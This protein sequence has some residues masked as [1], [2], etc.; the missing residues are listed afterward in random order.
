[1]TQRI[2]M[3]E[4]RSIIRALNRSNLNK[5]EFQTI[6][7]RIEE[8]TH[9]FQMRA[10]KLN[11][12][13]VLYRSN[14]Y[15][16]KPENV[17]FFSYPP[18][19]KVNGYQRCNAPK[20]PMFYCTPDPKTTYAELRLNAGDHVYLSK[21]VVNSDSLLIADPIQDVD[22]VDLPPVLEVIN[23]YFESKYLQPI[24]SDFSE[25]YKITAA[26][27]SVLVGT[28]VRGSENQFS[29]LHYPSVAD[30]NRSSNLV[31]FPSE[32]DKHLTLKQVD[33]V[34]ILKFDG[35][36]SEHKFID[37]S[38][39]FNSNGDIAWKGARRTYTVPKSGVLSIKSGGD[40]ILATD[41]M[42]NIVEPS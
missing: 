10:F 25:Q 2:S 42:G 20:S 7:K 36:R 21:W 32:V 33:E 37:F 12:G 41:D 38:S 13:Q 8:L 28:E 14:A 3:K 11:K 24:H 34:K 40:D 35:E 16:F 6:V 19:D 39:T 29:G 9:G 26:I 1:M 17:S 31:L 15:D 5:L 23:T 18:K 22:D 4:A 30:C 27:A